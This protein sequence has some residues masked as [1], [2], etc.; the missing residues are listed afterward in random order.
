[1]I[2]TQNIALSGL[3]TRRLAHISPTIAAWQLGQVC[4][5]GGISLFSNQD[6]I[7]TSNSLKRRMKT[8]IERTQTEQ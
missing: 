6:E 1:M 7:Q 4:Y 5:Y 8:P 3:R 2:K